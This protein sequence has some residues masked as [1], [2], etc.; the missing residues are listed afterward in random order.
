[1]TEGAL[2]ET[3]FRQTNQES[4]MRTILQIAAGL[5]V[6]TLLS[7]GDVAAQQAPSDKTQE[8]ITLFNEAD[9]GIA[10]WF[11]GAAGYAV[12]PNVGK[13]GLGIGGAHGNG[14]VIAGGH[15]LGKTEMTQVTVGLQAGGQSFIQIIFFKEKKDL[16]NFM[17]GDFEFNAQVSAVALTS[18]ASADAAYSHGVSVFTMAKEGLMAEVSIGGQKFKFEAY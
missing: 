14:E 16:D 13:G 11:S 9:P 7:Y 4:C 12:F 15:A 6:I 10:S 18:G 3:L 17:S 5:A 8:A 1:M 2:V